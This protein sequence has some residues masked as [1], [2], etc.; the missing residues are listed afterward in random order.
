MIYARGLHMSCVVRWHVGDLLEGSDPFFF[1]FLV[2]MEDDPG[3]VGE[4]G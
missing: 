4:A 2:S 1:L 3:N